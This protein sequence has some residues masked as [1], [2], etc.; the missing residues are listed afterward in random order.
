M[1]N[2]KYLLCVAIKEGRNFS[3]SDAVDDAKNSKVF[4]EVRFNGE[5]LR[6]DPVSFATTKPK[7]GSELAWKVDRKSLHLF[8]IQRK[9]IKL[10]CFIQQ[11]RYSSSFL[12]KKK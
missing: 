6:S 11:R 3:I 4:I 10:Q 5:T 8:R 1:E 2:S 7:F 9:P 12:N